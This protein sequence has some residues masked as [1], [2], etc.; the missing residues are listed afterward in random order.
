PRS[1]SS[2]PSTSNCPPSRRSSNVRALIRP[3][4][5]PSECHRNRPAKSPEAPAPGRRIWTPMSLIEAVLAREVLDSRGNPTVEVDAILTD[6][7]FGRA[8]WRSGASTGEHEA[9]EL[10][11][12]DPKRFGG[13]GVL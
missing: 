4:A 7:A 11:D 3:S 10:R 1:A 2:S 9:V 5:R 8:V 12:E 13:K 6:G